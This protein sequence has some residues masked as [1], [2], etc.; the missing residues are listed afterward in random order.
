MLRY[1]EVVT[2]WELPK[3]TAPGQT[4]GVSAGTAAVIGLQH[5]CQVDKPTTAYLMIGE[6]CARDCAFCTQAHSSIARSHFLSRI[7]WPPHPLQHVLH[8][9]AKGF[10]QGTIRRCCLQVT[11]FPGYLQQT[12]SVIELLRSLSSIPIGVSIV[13]SS[14]DA[15]RALLASGAERVTLALDAACERVYRGTKGSDWQ[16]R[17]NLLHKAADSFPG[18][19][20][21]HLIAGL[22][23]T[24][25]E[26]CS[27]LQE[28]VDRKVTIGLFS[29]TPVPG[30]VWA[31]HLPP[32]LP[33]YRR[34]QVARYLLA[35]GASRIEDWSFSPTGQIM[36]Y[37]LHPTKLRELLS[38]G[39]AFETAG[40]PDCNRPYYNE[41]P[42]KTM[43]NYPRPLR[44]EEIEAAI[45]VIMAEL[46]WK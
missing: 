2:M 29:F 6:R 8:A 46:T 18:H 39:R 43:Y 3:P 42:R 36:S 27:I 37:G 34:I 11:V 23:E 41:R 22:G 16:N 14:L 24:E 1:P 20:G 4:I 28:M 10:A 32:P 19:I 38:D 26:M 17:L 9:V 33:S 12:L 5:L 7:A 21:T 31:D 30:T 45:S 40:C 25:Q 15:I 13:V 35:T 44:V